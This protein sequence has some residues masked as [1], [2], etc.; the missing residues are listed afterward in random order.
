MP[1]ASRDRFANG[2]SVHLGALDHQRVALSPDRSRVG[3]TSPTALSGGCARGGFSDDGS[4]E[5]RTFQGA[6]SSCGRVA[7]G[8]PADPGGLDRWFG[9]GERRLN[10]TER[11]QHLGRGHRRGLDVRRHGVWDDGGGPRAHT[12]PCHLLANRVSARLVDRGWV[13]GTCSSAQQQQ[14]AHERELELT[15]RHGAH[16]RGTRR[17]SVLEEEAV[18]GF[19]RRDLGPAQRPPA[20]GAMLHICPEHMLEEKAPSMARACAGG[21]VVLA[22]QLQLIALGGCWLVGV[23]I[24]GVWDHFATE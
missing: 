10:W 5:R 20:A 11:G 8:G 2:W 3:A 22:E 13:S 7:R 15:E 17:E 14:S 18:Y 12:T 4:L 24:R 21:G 9:T 19:T 6:I 23:I 1:S 16:R